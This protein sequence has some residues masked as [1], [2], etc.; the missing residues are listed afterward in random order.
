MAFTKINAAGI[1][2]T[3]TVILDGLTVINDGSFGGN[4]SVGGTLTYEDV[5]NID[6][7]GL[8]TARAG[9]VV[10]SGITLS[11]DGDIFATGVTTAT[12]FVGD[13]S[14]LTGVASTEN[15]RTNTN[16][17]F[18]QNVNVS[19]S[20][21][22]GS[23]VSS[24]AIRSTTGIVT[25]LT[26]TDLTVDSGTT[27][28]CAIFKSTDAGANI[29]LIDDSARSTIEQNG[30][31]LRIISD[32]SAE[33]ANSTIKFQVDGG[34]KATIDSSGRLLLGTTTEGQANADNFTIDGGDAE[35]GITIRSGTSRG[36]HIYFSDGTSGDDEYR[37]IISYQHSDN[38]MQFFTNATEKLRITSAGKIGINETSPY[39]DIDI[40]SSVEDTDN[41]TLS[42]HGIR[43]HHDGAADEEV[44]PISAGFVSQQ[45]RARAAIGF[46]SKTISGSAGYG[47][48]IGFYTRKTA[49]GNA[50]YRTDERA[51][52]DESGN[53]SL[54][55][56]SVGTTNGAIGLKFGMKS[57]NNNAVTFE[58]SNATT[59]RGLLLESRLTGR[60]GGETFAQIHMKQEVGGQGGLINF[61]TAANGAGSTE[62]MR[63]SSAGYVTQPNMPSFL[64]NATGMGTKP[65][66]QDHSNTTW[67]INYL[68]QLPVFGQGLNSPGLTVLHN[69]GSHLTTHNFTTSGGSAATYV[70]FTAPVAG[71]Y[72]FF[73]SACPCKATISDWWGFGLNKNFTGNNSNGD[74][75][76]YM[77]SMNQAHDANQEV[78][79][80]GT[81]VVY[82]SAND[83]VI[84]YAR[85]CFR[86]EMTDRIV[87]GGHLLF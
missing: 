84:P 23:L 65:F 48:A 16:A 30:T 31:D 74:L 28:T 6:S 27:N 29:N 4:V 43:L 26:A 17:T 13:G 67:D 32:T 75:D 36:N 85:S 53:F 77:S 64:I 44:I 37:G 39:A 73:I 79:M 49:D 86:V 70:K 12:S 8:I 47:G 81:T 21:T 7:V 66:G 57:D 41:S 72:L 80:N 45:T 40:A 24:G 58:T 10:G 51:R 69:N 3:E 60:S 59:N 38:R 18:L 46:I 1:G 11:K 52:I 42:A 35:T 14:Q 76:Y 9:V 34:T 19:G 15:I 87:F 68:E 50:L 22:T 62:Q 20:T 25:T 2:S 82:M 54:G 33:H 61:Y 78:Q 56:T 71:Y 83:Y 5:T 55:T 63:I